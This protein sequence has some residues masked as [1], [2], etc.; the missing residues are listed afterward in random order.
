ML[1][2]LRLNYGNFPNQ[3]Y[4]LQ[5]TEHLDELIN[6]LPVVPKNVR[7]KVL[8]LHSLHGL[9][10]LRFGVTDIVFMFTCFVSRFVSRFVIFKL[11]YIACKFLD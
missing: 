5:N 2:N 11:Y 3:V 4:H 10:S 6:I 7:K 9:H 8:S 1:A